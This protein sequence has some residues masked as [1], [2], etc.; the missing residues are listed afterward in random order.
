MAAC[1]KHSI[2]CHQRNIDSSLYRCQERCFIVAKQQGP[3]TD[4]QIT[5]TDLICRQFVRQLV[6]RINCPEPK[7][8]KDFLS[9]SYRSLSH[10]KGNIDM[11]LDEILSNASRKNIPILIRGFAN[12]NGPMG[13]SNATATIDG[14]FQ[15][16][17]R[18][19]MPDPWCQIQCDDIHGTILKTIGYSDLRSMFAADPDSRE[20]TLNILD[21]P[22][23]SVVRLLEDVKFP[24]FISSVDIL[25][26]AIPRPH[27]AE[28]LREGFKAPSVQRWMICTMAGYIT[29]FHPRHSGVLYCD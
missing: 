29:E 20:F 17:E 19:R 28:K 23:Q 3:R 5:S 24:K 18:L 4:V 26:F 21:L 11:V 27:R 7:H 13:T 8:G 25:P 15:H 6:G 22:L 9:Y 1:S 12:I 2:T 10:R 14:F 16:Q